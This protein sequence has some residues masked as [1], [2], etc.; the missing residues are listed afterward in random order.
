LKNVLDDLVII[1]KIEKEKKEQ[2]EALLTEGYKSQNGSDEKINFGWEA[3]SIE[4]WPD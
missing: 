1:E 2:F 4:G 3:I